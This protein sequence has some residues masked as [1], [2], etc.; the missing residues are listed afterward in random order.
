MER[1]MRVL[2]LACLFSVM[3]S[4]TLAQTAESPT[5][6]PSPMITVIGAGRAEE[7]A[8]FAWLNFTLRGEGATSPEAV[9][10]LA[11]ARGKLEVSLKALPGKPGLDVRS[12]TLSIREVRPKSCT[13]N[14]GG[15]AL[16]T[17]ECAVIGSIAVVGFQVKVNP[18]KQVGDVASLAAQLGASDVSVNNGGLVDDRSLEG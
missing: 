18:A 8:D 13:N 2:P 14:Y 7:P 16:S 4:I 5:A 6:P 12:G 9:S 10:A 15:P 1:F 11:K 17:G 3:S